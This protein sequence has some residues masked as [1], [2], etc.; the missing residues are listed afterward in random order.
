MAIV[1]G[2]ILFQIILIACAEFP[3]EWHAW[4][5]THDISY[6]NEYEEQ[7]RHVVW[8][9]NQEYIDQHNKYEEQFGYTLEMNKFGDMVCVNT[10]KTL[11]VY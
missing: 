4:K 9:S 5:A 11:S 6:E 10:G 1:Y 8:Q 3:P 2:A 7:K